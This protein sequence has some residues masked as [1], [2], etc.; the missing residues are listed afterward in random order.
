MY[1]FKG[2]RDYYKEKFS[3]V[4]SAFGGKKKHLKELAD[5]NMNLAFGE[6]EYGEVDEYKKSMA[7]QKGMSGHRYEM[8]FN[9][10][11]KPIAIAGIVTPIAFLV[12][13]LVLTRGYEVGASIFLALIT[14]AV[15]GLMYFNAS[16]LTKFLPKGSLSEI[17]NSKVVLADSYVEYSYSTINPKRTEGDSNA[18]FVVKRMNYKD[19]K[20]IVY[21]EKQ[22]CC[23][24][25]GRY[26]YTK[27]YEYKIGQENPV[28]TNDTR[29]G[30]F[31]LYDVYTNRDLFSELSSKS[32]VSAKYGVAPKR[33]VLSSSFFTLCFS[34]A[35]LIGVSFVGLIIVLIALLF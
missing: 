13:S 33:G 4:F 21:Y 17:V 25:Y 29:D 7:E 31:M 10:L 26:S 3:K 28:Y 6:G 2:K 14:A 24:V 23:E 16:K 18:N 5:K 12:V 1:R 30:S 35:G 34:G 11:K 19:I 27:Y 22:G 9:N 8:F 32:R 20:G 15:F